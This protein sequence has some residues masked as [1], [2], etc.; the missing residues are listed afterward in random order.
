MKKNTTVKVR[1]AQL[2]ADKEMRLAQA[3]QADVVKLQKACWLDRHPIIAFFYAWFGR[4][5]FDWS[6]RYDKRYLLTWARENEWNASRLVKAVETVDNVMRIHA[7]FKRRRIDQMAKRARA[8][9][10]W[11]AKQKEAK[12][13]D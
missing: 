7:N 1:Q 12:Q 6:H 2:R 11:N 10:K 9:M 3:R 8:I 13:N 4:R 5:P